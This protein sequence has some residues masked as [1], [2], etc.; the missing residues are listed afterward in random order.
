M[1]GICSPRSSTELVVFHVVCWMSFWVV[2]AWLLGCFL[3]CFVVCLV[4]KTPSVLLSPILQHVR[5]ANKSQEVLM[6]V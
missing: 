3:L 5:I 4:L 2:L 6:T 1:N